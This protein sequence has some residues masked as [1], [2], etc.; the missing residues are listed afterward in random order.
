MEEKES[1]NVFASPGIH[2]DLTYG[3]QTINSPS[4]IMSQRTLL[5]KIHRSC[6]CNVQ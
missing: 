3:Q 4:L 5:V 2:L 1:A 6:Q